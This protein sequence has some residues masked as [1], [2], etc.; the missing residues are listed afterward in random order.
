MIVKM[1][2]KYFFFN[3]T[4]FLTFVII[5]FSLDEKLS[6]IHSIAL[7]LSYLVLLFDNNVIVPNN[8][9]VQNLSLVYSFIDTSTTEVWALKV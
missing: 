4:T 7:V 5:F 6:L 8:I 1:D 9:T 3:F 2:S